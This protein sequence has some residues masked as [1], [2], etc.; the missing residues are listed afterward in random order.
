MGSRNHGNFTRNLEQ[1]I[2]KSIQVFEQPRVPPLCEWIVSFT[3]IRMI[4]TTIAKRLASILAV[5]Q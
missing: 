3:D 2:W 4:Y 1:L 5:R